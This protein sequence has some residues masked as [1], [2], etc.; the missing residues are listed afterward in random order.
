VHEGDLLC[1]GCFGKG[2]MQVMR[3]IPTPPTWL[4]DQVLL[5]EGRGCNL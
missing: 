3:T 2:Q 1:I 5:Q 4:S